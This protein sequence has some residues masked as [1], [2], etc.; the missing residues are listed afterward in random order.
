MTEPIAPS[1][2]D[3]DRGY[4]F[5]PGDQ[6]DHG[7]VIYNIDSIDGLGL[8]H[9]PYSALG[10]IEDES[11]SGNLVRVYRCRRGGLGRRLEKTR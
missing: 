11:Y 10:L 5:H 4:T 1:T 8:F 6:V 3:H 7:G 2:A 9:T